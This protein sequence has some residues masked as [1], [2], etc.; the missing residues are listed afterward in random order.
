MG[1]IE[2]GNTSR[3]I[4]VICM[5][6]TKLVSS[7]TLSSQ[8]KLIPLRSQASSRRP[9]TTRRRKSQNHRYPP[10][11]RRRRR[12]LPL[13]FP[14]HPLHAQN[15]LRPHHRQLRHRETFALHPLCRPQARRALPALFTTGSVPGSQWRCR[16][17]RHDD[18]P[19]GD[20]QDLVYGPNLHRQE[21][22]GCVCPHAQ[23]IDAGAGG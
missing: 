10:T 11:P 12:H 20:P 13:E 1:Q 6:L 5:L 17:R 9:R 2:I 3:Q 14:R 21:N 8:P 22:Y 16:P 23:E 18:H 7:L 19:P 15:R 4:A